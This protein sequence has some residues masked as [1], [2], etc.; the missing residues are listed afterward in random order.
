VTR[1]VVDASVVV[2][3]LLP[4]RKDE[5]DAERALALLEGVKAGRITVHQPVHW[6]AEVAAVLVRLSPATVAD[7]LADLHAMNFPVEAGPEVYLDAC[8]LARSLNHHV[9]DTL[10]HAV[11]LTLPG[12]VLVTADARYERKGRRRGAIMLLHDMAPA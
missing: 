10:Y 12:T 9:F 11:A 6:L 1:V 7:D 8:E 2:K 4:E 5:G 3:W